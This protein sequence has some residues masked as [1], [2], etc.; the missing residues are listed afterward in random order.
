MKKNSQITLKLTDEDFEFLKHVAAQTDFSAQ[1]MVRQMIAA[2]RRQW[3]SAGRLS[4]PLTLADGGGEA[5]PATAPAPA[6]ATAT[7]TAKAIA[8]SP[9][10][11]K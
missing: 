5:S 9:R 11:R 7:A 10:A 3:E 4:L 8:K 2:V 1:A 6:T